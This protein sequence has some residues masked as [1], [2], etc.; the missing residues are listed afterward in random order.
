ML[1]HGHNVILALCV[2]NYTDYCKQ[3]SFARLNFP[4]IH[5]IIMDSCSNIFVVQGQNAYMLLLQQKIHG[6]NFCT[7]LKNCENRESLVQ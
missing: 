7:P 4:G 5:I 2:I 3:E 6:V 1:L